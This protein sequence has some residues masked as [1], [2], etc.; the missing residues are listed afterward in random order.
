MT[1]DPPESIKKT[2]LRGHLNMGFALNE[3]PMVISSFIVLTKDG[4]DPPT[5]EDAYKTFL[6]Q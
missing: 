6:Q 5:S 1:G 4:I 2:D 3:I